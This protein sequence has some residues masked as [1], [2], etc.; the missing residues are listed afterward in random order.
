[1]LESH[2][3]DVPIEANSHL[4]CKDGEPVD[5]GQYQR[6]IGRMIYLSHTWP[7]IAYVVTLVSQYMHLEAAYH[8]LRYL[9]SA[10][11][12]GVLFSSHGHLKV[13]AL[14]DANW[15]GSP[16]DCMSTTGYCTFVGGN[17]VN[18]RSKKQTVVARSS[19]EAEFRA[20]VHGICE[21]L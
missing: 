4:K 16:D 10:P 13:E 17:L 19:A 12:K 9:K 3:S 5:K 11:G 18:W 20:M 2:P 6:L 7:D 14:I 21:L 1:M 8:I 15:A